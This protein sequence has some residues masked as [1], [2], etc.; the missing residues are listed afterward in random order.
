LN[1]AIA[2]YNAGAMR[3]AI[4]ATWIAVSFN[5]IDKINTLETQGDK[6]AKDFADEFRKIREAADVAG[7][8]AFERK[9]LER[10]RVAHSFGR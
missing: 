3:A 8:L 6:Q 9:I 5:F 7:S 4:I 2:S 1:E 10:G